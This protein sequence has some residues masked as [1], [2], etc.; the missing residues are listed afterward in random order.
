MHIPDLPVEYSWCVLRQRL[1]TF[2]TIFPMSADMPRRFR[3]NLDERT[4]PRSLFSFSPMRLYGSV[5]TVRQSD[6]ARP[7]TTMKTGLPPTGTHIARLSVFPSS[8]EAF[9]TR[10]RRGQVR[11]V[12]TDRR[13]RLPCVCARGNWARPRA[14]TVR[15]YRTK[16]WVCR[17]AYAKKPTLA[18]ERTYEAVSMCPAD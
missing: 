15:Q 9:S 13:T 3:L 1:Y 12:C 7:Y 11:F 4:M 6:S 8:P 14:T 2:R 17:I 10:S 16:Q 18:V 5:C